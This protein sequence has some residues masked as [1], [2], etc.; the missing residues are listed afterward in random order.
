M[1]MNNRE[2]S[3]E[4]EYGWRQASYHGPSLARGTAAFAGEN[5]S[6]T[7]KGRG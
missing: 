3:M 2:N 1:I 6:C 4:S 5:D 7:V